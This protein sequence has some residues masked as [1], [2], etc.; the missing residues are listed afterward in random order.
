M[1]LL[2]DAIRDHLDLKRRR[3]AD[4]GEVERAE[5]EA[6]GP[7]RRNPTP[8][9]L[10]EAEAAAVA[11]DGIAYDQGADEDWSHDSLQEPGTEAGV[12]EEPAADAGVYDEP[13]A[14][15]VPPPEFPGADAAPVRAFDEAPGPEPFGDEPFGE[16][17]FEDEEPARER[18]APEPE[19]GAPPAMGGVGP[20]TA[21]FNVEDALAA[22]DHR[23]GGDD[24]DVLE[25]TPEFLQDTPDHDRLWF[26]QRPPKDFDFD[27]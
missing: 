3:G 8:S 27:E 5:R 25:E 17:P 21:E 6:L 16:E 19:R 20:E 13:A 12:Y 26:E 11:E 18:Y 22:E 7:V 2:D 15:P 24:D 1:G 23:T 9:E 10:A 4:P 14:A